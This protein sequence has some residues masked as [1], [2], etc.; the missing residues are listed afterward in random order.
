M[1]GSNSDIIKA[2][3]EILINTLNFTLM[4]QVTL[5][6]Q[7]GKSLFILFN[8]CFSEHINYINSE[9]Y[10]DHFKYLGT[11]LKRWLLQ[12][13]NQDENYRDQRSI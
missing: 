6:F 1:I 10:T 7:P 2:H 4:C 11:L 3:S 9:Y 12:K 8:S 5:I 13:G